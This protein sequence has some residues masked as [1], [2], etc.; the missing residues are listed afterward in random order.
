M[1]D[2]QV[3]EY[4]SIDGVGRFSIWRHTFKMAVVMSFHA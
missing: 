1:I 4:A 2:L 3:N